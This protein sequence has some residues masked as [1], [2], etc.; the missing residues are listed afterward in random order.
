VDVS[1]TVRRRPISTQRVREA[2]AAAL[3]AER[4]REALI[5]VAFIGTD[6]M[7]KLNREFLSHNAPTDVISFGMRQSDKALPVIG[8]IYIC[9]RIAE[10]N[11]RSLGIPLRE[12]LERLV[13]HGTLHI[14]W[15]DHPEGRGR[16]TSP[17]WKRQERI[18]D[19]LH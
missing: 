7:A 11:A 17:M 4:I 10:R 18:L 6:A 2:V 12:E 1:F 9:P 14:L 13:I 8:D 3:A 16:T 15:Y 5:S 19:S